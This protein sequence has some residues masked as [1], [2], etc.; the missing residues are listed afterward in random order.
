[1][2]PPNLRRLKRKMGPTVDG[3]IGYNA[4]DQWSGGR[5]T[6]APEQQAPGFHVGMVMDDQDDQKM[7]RVW[8]YIPEFSGKRFDELSLPTWGG[9]TPDRQNPN[10]LELDQKLRTQW[11]LVSVMQPFFG[12]DDYRTSAGS[13][14]R[15][16]KHGDVNAYGSWFQP[17]IGDFVGVMFVG[18]DVNNGFVVG[19]VPK[20]YRN[21]M[22]P[23]QPG[24]AQPEISDRD[25]SGVPPIVSEDAFL[26]AMDKAPSDEDPRHIDRLAASQLS[27]N[28]AYSG[29]SADQARGAGT[30][31][32]RR[33]SPSYVL[34]FKT[35][36]WNFGSERKNR[37]VDGRQFETRKG[38]LSRVNTTGHSFAMDDHPDYQSI[39][40]R[41]SNGAQLFFNDSCSTPYIYMQT[42]TGK[43]WIEL[44]DAGAINIYAAGSINMHAEGSM[45]TTVDGDYNIQV[46]GN[47][48]ML[49][50]GNLN[51]TI[52]G[53]TAI[54]NV[55]DERRANSGDLDHSITGTH[56]LR[57]ENAQEVTIGTT[58]TISVTS[59]Q[60]ITVD[61]THILN[62]SGSS[63]FISSGPASIEASAIYLNSGVIAEADVAEEP[64]L[65]TFAQPGS[66]PGAPTMDE[67]LK[68]GTPGDKEFLPT[69]VPQHQPWAGRCGVGSTPGTNGNVTSSPTGVEDVRNTENFTCDPGSLTN[70][71]R[72]GAAR[73]GAVRPDNAVGTRV[74]EEPCPTTYRGNTYNTESGAE[75]PTAEASGT[76][77]AEQTHLVDS[78][79]LSPEGFDFIRMQETLVPFPR[80]DAFGKNYIVGYGHVVKVGDVIGGKEISREDL[81]AIRQN[82]NDTEKAF[83]ITEAEANAFLSSEVT[84]LQSKLDPL[85]GAMTE[86][87]QE[88]YDAINSFTRNV[89]L[90]NL[91]NDPVGQE[92]LTAIAAGDMETA[93]AAMA[94]FSH[95]GNKVDCDTLDRRRAEINKMGT[96]VGAPGAVDNIDFIPDGQTVTFGGYKM[97]GEVFNAIANAQAAYPELPDGYLF[98]I[99]SQESAFKAGIQAETSSAAGLFQFIKSTGSKY[100]LST[101][102]EPGSNVFDP[103]ANANAGAQFNADN[104]RRL[105]SGLTRTPNATDLYFAHFLGAGSASRGTGAI[106][107]LQKADA[108]PTGT[109]A[110]DGFAKQARANRPVFFFKDGTPK[111]YEQIYANFA[112][113]ISCRTVKFQNANATA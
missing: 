31:G 8:V 49:V 46:N 36:G 30:S 35:A 69:V 76:A 23:G 5:T 113:K 64:E 1:M 93:Q 38:T 103:V 75:A 88:Q 3:G 21:A 42:Q 29:L 13:D 83:Q 52:N 73:S 27:R 95:V 34:G 58:Q 70:N 7:G 37:D 14:G 79:S 102:R 50:G 11:L 4:R 77:E 12:S 53:D 92:Y 111:T 108:N 9:T 51:R 33:E 72:R 63:Y 94:K 74:G 106:G 44:A 19:M 57:V 98:A 47:Y 105:Q 59:D 84:E 85:L 61:G 100:G 99:A 16:S 43:V 48:N 91:Q 32:A 10:G 55:G 45:N 107:F 101:S 97:T 24:V 26:P 80:L 104:F 2:P 109:P 112:R 62:V 6:P 68:N 39:R 82:S 86:F 40:F 18:G 25:G 89:G 56:S 20:Q 28:I 54:L 60:N 87:T 96:P 66:K 110:T 78:L 90:E 81:I 41:T 22:V 71:V 15:N 17:R 65:P 67:I